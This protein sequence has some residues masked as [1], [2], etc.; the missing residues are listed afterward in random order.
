MQRTS[1]IKAASVVMVGALA[2][3]ACGSSSKNSTA[4]T[5]HSASTAAAGSAGSSTTASSTSYPP[6]PAGPI[7]VC[8]SSPQSGANAA[9][10]ETVPKSL[11]IAV[12]IIN[13]QGGI[14]GHQ[15]K[16]DAENDQSSSTDA[17]SIAQKFAS[18]HAA[19]P[20]VCPFATTISQD[21]L[22]A[23][24][25]AGIL[26]KAKIIIEATQSPDDFFDTGK[27][28]YFFSNSPPDKALGAAAAHYLLA[29]NE[30]HLGV[31]TDNIPQETEYI[32]DMKAAATQ[33]GGTLDVTA[34]AS[35]SPGAVNVQTQLL[36]LKQANPDVVVVA[37][38]FGFGPIWNGFKA[39]GWS[40][41]IMGDVGFFYDGYNALGNLA[42]NAVAPCWYG[43]QP[44]IL[45]E[46]A[47]QDGLTQDVINVVNQIA[48]LNGGIA[49]DSLIAA[50]DQMDELYM[51][52]YAIEKANTLDPVALK[53]ALET[54]NGNG[55]SL[56]YS[57][58]TFSE[59]AQDHS[60]QVGQWGAGI[61]QGAPLGKVG[62]YPNFIYAD[63]Y[64]A[65]G[66]LNQPS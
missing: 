30:T 31:L 40:P 41:K 8:A 42:A 19:N 58:N 45:Q 61:C 47:G 34:T 63:N 35:M 50:S 26:N 66:G 32:N 21:P 57:T 9:Y 4:T 60:G 49:P 38:E 64:R 11:A 13:Q 43:N 5:A 33:Q 24:L 25:Q 15:V 1:A 54:L 39:L 3:T 16:Y 27:Y 59:T 46:N 2:L 12:N 29:H 7:T 37:T 48:P 52:K 23:P 53:N 36:Q 14:A 6:I 65:P 20:S 51:A 56:W 62:N 28:P 10:G 17:V 44:G 18:E 22:T 55:A